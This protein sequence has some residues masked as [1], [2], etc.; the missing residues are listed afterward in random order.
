MSD[1]CLTHNKNRNMIV[2]GL[3]DK[4]MIET[5][6][7]YVE[8]KR[9][10]YNQG[11]QYSL[12]YWNEEAVIFLKKYGLVKNKSL[13]L[14]YP[15]SIPDEF[16]PDFIR[17]FFDADGSIVYHKTKWNTY[18]QVSIV[19]G[20]RRFAEGFTIALQNYGIE[21]HIYT[22]NRRGNNNYYIRITKINEVKKFKKLIY[23]NDTNFKLKRKYEKFAQLDYINKIYSNVAN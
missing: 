7:E 6:H 19:T 22:S 4:E 1:G 23:Q 20:S 16:Q 11:N 15:N 17:G 10:I 2:I 21:S 13:I 3:N 12:Y 8:C 14:E 9:K 5:L 18:P